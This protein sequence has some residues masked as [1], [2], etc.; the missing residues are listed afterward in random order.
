MTPFALLPP[1]GTAALTA[2]SEIPRPRTAYHP[3]ID[4]GT[5]LFGLTTRAVRQRL[6]ST[7]V[8]FGQLEGLL[9][10]IPPSGVGRRRL[11]PAC[12]VT[13]SVILVTGTL[14][15]KIADRWGFLDVPDGM[16]GAVYRARE[17]AEV[18][19]NGGMQMSKTAFRDRLLN[20][21]RDNPVPWTL[22]LATTLAAIGIAVWG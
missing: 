18:R 1:G 9:G 6:P 19:Q 13:S 20:L 2:E 4:C 3:I 21:V 14:L 15:R 5:A 8:P 11:F 16:V 22:F 7:W 17:V 10:A 12:I